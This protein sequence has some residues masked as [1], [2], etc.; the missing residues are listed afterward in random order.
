MSCMRISILDANFLCSMNE[1][2]G[3]NLKAYIGNQ[4]C[5]TEIE[6]ICFMSENEVFFVDPVILEK[7]NS[8]L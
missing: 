1:I 2:V 6:R 3:I 7:Y 4:S 8:I 5:K